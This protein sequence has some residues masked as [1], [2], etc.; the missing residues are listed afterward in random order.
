M[1][2]GDPKDRRIA[3]LEREN[4][5]LRKL[6]EKLRD[7]IKELEKKQ[8]R[9]KRQATPFARKKR[10]K[11]RKKPGRKAGHVGAH[12]QKPDHVDEEL[13]ADLDVC[14]HCVRRSHLKPEEFQQ[15]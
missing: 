15:L 8:R 12:Q 7:R 13:R 3:E 5:E 2:D 14:P 1:S 6:I 4:A 10:K 9:G 11:E